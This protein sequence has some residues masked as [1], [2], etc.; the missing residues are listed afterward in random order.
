MTV[1]TTF[2]ANLVV[3]RHDAEPPC[4]GDKFLNNPTSNATVFG[5][6]I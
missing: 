4:G 2:N 5:K 3:G 6:T 1:V